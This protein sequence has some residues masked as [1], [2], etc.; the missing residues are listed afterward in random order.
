MDLGR[1]DAILLGLVVAIIGFGLWA[2][3][4]E[5]HVVTVSDRG[6][7]TL[8]TDALD[9]VLG[10]MDGGALSGVEEDGMVAAHVAE[11]EDAQRLAALADGGPAVLGPVADAERTH[12]AGVALLLDRYGVEPDDLPAAPREN[13]TGAAALRAAV[14]VQERSVAALDERLRETDNDDLRFVYERLQRA[15]RNHLRLL[16]DAL[17]QRNSSAEPSVLDADRF[18]SI[19]TGD[20]ER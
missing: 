12:A 6:V 7:T 15:S 13:L 8:E 14:T 10:E 17:R 19:V 18:E 5:Q 11:R 4:P 20:I 1:N 9:R 16:D 3:P 2:G